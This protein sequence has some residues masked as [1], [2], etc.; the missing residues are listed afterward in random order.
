V[1]DPSKDLLSSSGTTPSEAACRVSPSDSK[2]SPTFSQLLSCVDQ[3]RQQLGY[4]ST[5]EE[6]LLACVG[7]MQ[8][9][10]CAQNA[11]EAERG[12]AQEERISRL[13]KELNAARA[14]EE[15][16]REQ[17]I[18]FQTLHAAGR[19]T[20]LSTGSTT[21]GGAPSS[22]S[23][24]KPFSEG[25][26]NSIPAKPIPSG[27]VSKEVLVSSSRARPEMLDALLGSQSSRSGTSAKKLFIDPLL[28]SRE[29]S[30]SGSRSKC[31][32]SGGTRAESP[33]MP[34][35]KSVAEPLALIAST[36]RPRSP[37]GERKTVGSLTVTEELSAVSLSLSTLSDNVV[38]ALMGAI[39]SRF[40]CITE[41]QL[42]DQIMRRATGEKMKAMIDSM[43][44]LT[45]GAG[46]SSSM[47]VVRQDSLSQSC[48]GIVQGHDSMRK[49][50]P[51]KKRETHMGQGPFIGESDKRKV[52]QNFFNTMPK[53]CVQVD[54]MERVRND[55]LYERFQQCLQES[56]G[57]EAAYLCLTDQ[58]QLLRIEEEG[59]CSTDFITSELGTGIHVGTHAGVAHLSAVNKTPQ[60]PR[61]SYYMC[62]LLCCPGKLNSELSGTVTDRLESPR[63]YCILEP[64]RLY[65]A[66]VIR[67]Q[68]R[69]SP[70]TR[71]TILSKIDEVEQRAAS[72]KSLVGQ[73]KV[74]YNTARDIVVDAAVSNLHDVVAGRIT[75]G[76]AMQLLDRDSDEARRVVWLYACG[77]GAN[78]LT[79][80]KV[81]RIENLELFRSFIDYS[82]ES[83]E[84][85]ASKL[86]DQIVWHGA[87]LKHSDG[88]CTPLQ[89]KLQSIAEQGFDPLRCE[90]GATAHGGIWAATAPL[91]S[92]GRGRDGMVAFVL[93]LA[94][95][96]FNEWVDTSC[97]R[98]LERERV[99]P[100]YAVVHE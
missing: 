31:Y 38:P 41:L 39:S 26:R 66:Y 68:A 6:H 59:F 46:S 28:S 16:L 33:Q 40:Q 57:S 32:A 69:D 20:A 44:K 50:L 47:A 88:D 70:T 29:G 15:L 75:G 24:S 61:G 65:V 82:N 21:S 77:G 99:L 72:N 52:L 43:H 42:V 71:A 56:E 48:S 7:D 81:W 12:A 54:K 4:Q 10:L 2:P 5:Q 18:A 91:A 36:P 90:K 35:V 8:K 74:C 11:L 58:V 34:R 45:P 49:S 83:R 63:E 67:Y 23:S 19:G 17:V 80:V 93:C 62:V 86:R 73:Q 53:T 60:R 9:Q 95:T 89:M 98:V 76:P 55:E 100:L 25:H 94:K 64:Q 13:E 37:D 22:S 96:F 3:I 85:G 87:K 84:K 1:Q 97:V 78:K 30:P 27:T 51:S 92:F 79:T 14:R